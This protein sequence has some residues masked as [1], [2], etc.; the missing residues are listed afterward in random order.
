MYLSEFHE[1]SNLN[2]DQYLYLS[3]ISLTSLI[4]LHDNSIEN[5]LYFRYLMKFNEPL[6]NFSS[7]NPP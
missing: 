7:Y 5:F 2:L 6:E 3:C 1:K 4:L